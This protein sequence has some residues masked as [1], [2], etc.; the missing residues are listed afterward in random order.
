MFELKKSLI[1]LIAVLT[2]YGVEARGESFLIPNVEGS[3]YITT[4]MD[5]GPPTLRLGPIFDLSGPGLSVF[6]Q[7]MPNN[8]A[9]NVEAR[10]TCI[11]IPCTPGQVIGT[12]SNYLGLLSTPTFTSATVNGSFYPFVR[13]TGSLVF[14]SEPIVLPNFGSSPPVV[15]IPFNFAGQITGI[16]LQPNVS[17]AEL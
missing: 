3:V 11:E 17:H 12:N 8:N 15:T 16:A 6:T 7:S 4:S 9:G 10:D 13:V 14:F 1:A 2:L 5:G